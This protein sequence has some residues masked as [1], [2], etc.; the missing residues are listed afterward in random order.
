MQFCY[1]QKPFFPSANSYLSLCPKGTEHSSNEAEKR[2]KNTDFSQLQL[3][4]CAYS[5]TH[6]KW[7]GRG[8]NAAP[9]C[10][11]KS[12]ADQNQ[13]RTQRKQLKRQQENIGKATSVLHSWHQPCPCN[14]G[15]DTDVQGYDTAEYRLIQTGVSESRIGALGS[16]SL[17]QNCVS[18][19]P[20]QMWDSHPTEVIGILPLMDVGCRSNQI[21]PAAI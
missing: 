8:R 13:N 7:K 14:T 10:P 18:W 6:T 17:V 12:P 3:R 20:L 11:L 2:E 21:P 1:S 19:S 5:H 16:Y 9:V 15:S 4:L